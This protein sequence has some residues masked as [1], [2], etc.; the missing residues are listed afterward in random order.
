MATIKQLTTR[1][2]I[3]K[4]KAI[5]LW[6]ETHGHISNICR[7]LDI[8]R[9][10]FYAWLKADKAFAQALFD[11]EAE[12]N[13]EVRD[14]LIQKIANGDMTGIIFYLK[15]RHPDFL[16]KKPNT[17]VQVNVSPILNGESRKIK[18]ITEIKQVK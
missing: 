11:A 8:E 6:R 15:N 7:T 16:E 18:P 9:K 13:D 5:E 12:L 14:A 4:Q 2:N 1:R 10:T 3:K 17:M